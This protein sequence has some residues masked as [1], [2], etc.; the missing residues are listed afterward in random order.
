MSNQELFETCDKFLASVV[1]RLVATKPFYAHA[2]NGMSKEFDLNMKF[3][4]AVS[5]HKGDVVLHLS[6]EK[7]LTLNPNEARAVLEHEILHLVFMHALRVGG[8]MRE[9]F[10]IAADAAINQLLSDLPQNCVDYARMKLPK[11]QTAETYYNLIPDDMVPQ[12]IKFFIELDDHSM[13]KEGDEADSEISE[14]GVKAWVR[15]S[16]E[17]SRGTIP[18]ELQKHLPELLK[19]KKVPWNIILRMFVGTLGKVVSGSTW[20]KPNRRG[21]ENP[22]V[23]KSPTINLCVCIDTSGSVSDQEISLFFSEINRLYD[24]RRNSLFIIESDAG[25]HNMY[26][27][28]GKIPS[29]RSRGG[30]AFTPALMEAD[31]HRPRFDGIIYLTDGYGD[32]PVKCTSIRTLWVVTPGGSVDG[33]AQ[34]GK[35]IRMLP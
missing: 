6:P 7:F 23:R 19:E 11:D 22:G 5:V 10:N 25:V 12:Y 34:F 27:Y 17:K 29:K 33:C 4:A 14:L 28:K 20:K 1:H 21:L 24:D 3:I 2:I 31:K 8:R 32:N 30:T 15:E 18:G 26:P 9:K 13:W 35:I 16:V